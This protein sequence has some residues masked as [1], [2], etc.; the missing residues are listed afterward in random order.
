MTRVAR[1]SRLRIPMAVA[2]AWG[3]IAGCSAGSNDHEDTT[4][5]D[6]VCVPGEQT[7]CDCPG[8]GQG[9]QV[10]RDDGS[11]Y[12]EC[13]GCDGA[14]GAVNEA[15]AAG[16][17]NEG[18]AAGQAGAGVGGSAGKGGATGTGG[19]SGKGGA[20]G[21]GGSAGKGGAAGQ[22]GAVAD[23]CGGVPA[24]GVCASGN[25]VQRCITSGD[26][27]PTVI[28]QQCNSFEQ[29]Q[30]LAGIAQCAVKSG[31]CSPGASRCSSQ[32]QLVQ[33]SANAAWEQ[34]TC[35]TTCR[36]SPIGAFCDPGIAT[37]GKAGTLKYE[38]RDVNSSTFNQWGSVFQANA[39]GVLMVSFRNDVLIDATY[40]DKDGAFY[41]KVP[42][43]VAAGDS[44]YALL[45]RPMSGGVNEGISFAVMDPGLGVG[46]QDEMAFG[47]NQSA[48]NAAF[49]GWQF[50]LTQWTSFDYVIPEGYGSGAARV[51]DWLRYLMGS[52][53]G[54]FGSAP[55]P[56]VLWMQ[57]EV[58][59]NCGACAW[60]VPISAGNFSFQSQIFMPMDSANQQYWSGAVTAHEFGHY[61][62]SVWGTS[63]NEGGQHCFGKHY[64]SG[65]V[66]SEGWATWFSAENRR[67]TG[68]GEV[69]YDKQQGSFFNFN[70]ATRKYSGTTAWVRPVAASGLYQY[71]D[72]NESAAMLF[73]LSG[74]PQVGAQPL[75]TALTSLRMNTSP[76]ARGYTT[77]TWAPGL[78]DPTDVVD[79]G[80]S[81][82]MLADFFD[83][84][85]C[86]GVPAWAIDQVTDPTTNFPYPSNDPICN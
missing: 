33:C 56:L 64:P 53:E 8:G 2:A 31:A 48:S 19:T 77:H 76:F 16:E 84:L 83:A 20:A 63:P 34:F 50:D 36:D 69:Y 57:N 27:T 7:A 80:V 60:D 12:D 14:G 5:T 78:C 85:N 68:Y 71:M 49:W 15:G 10:C 54:Y 1:H 47:G 13:T 55:R 74:N 44:V 62:M 67:Y 17:P 73:E 18:G 24:N 79:T 35:P 40:T 75:Y 46:K 42:S 86:S 22:G 30:V 66:W 25:K 37:T 3:A 82:P 52:S 51:F 81:A 65:L 39:P 23:P 32:S 45:V 61:A 43:S 21:A 41:I 38:A 9:A 59:W 4:G 6:P 70:L 11:G 72:E 28:T 29:C 26:A 58:T